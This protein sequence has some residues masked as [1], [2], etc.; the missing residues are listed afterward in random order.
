MDQ[1]LLTALFIVALFAFLGTGVWVGI[2]LVGVSAL[3][4]A[5]V[6]WVSITGES[7][8]LKDFGVP[9]AIEMAEDRI[10]TVTPPNNVTVRLRGPESLMRRLE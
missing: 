1:L 9:L 7:S 3:G 5:F 10:L 6:I 4:M 8:I 2:A